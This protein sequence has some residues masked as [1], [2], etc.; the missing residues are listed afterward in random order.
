MTE[1]ITSKGINSYITTPDFQLVCWFAD[2]HSGEHFHRDFYELAVI[3]SGHGIHT[4]GGISSEVS[5]GDILLIPPGQPHNYSEY[6]KLDLYNLLFTPQMMRYFLP[7]LTRTIGF[8]RIFDNTA[9]SRTHF[10]N[11]R[12][13]DEYFHEI[14]ALLKEMS[15]LSD[16]TMP[17]TQMI[18]LSDFIRVITLISLHSKPGFPDSKNHHIEEISQFLSML[19]KNYTDQWDLAKMAHSCHMSVSN[20]RQIFRQVTSMPPLEYLIR[21]RLLRAIAMLESSDKNLEEIA[22]NCGFGS[23]NYLSRQ[24]RKNYNITPY[25]YRKEYQTGQREPLGTA[26]PHR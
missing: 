6:D 13:C 23:A 21:L 19:E 10:S 16:N 25:R 18:I 3:S 1:N 26:K 2:H 14:F 20:F 9:D 11:L 4:I 7:D 5:T 24:F 15:S 17:G 8:Q 12:I 22:Y